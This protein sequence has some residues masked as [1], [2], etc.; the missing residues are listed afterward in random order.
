MHYLWDE[1]LL[2]ILFVASRF[3]DVVEDKASARKHEGVE[4]VDATPL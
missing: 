1:I 2:N 4:V 3:S